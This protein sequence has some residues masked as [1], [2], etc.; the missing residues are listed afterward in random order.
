MA[1][2]YISVYFILGDCK[3]N[4]FA[5]FNYKINRNIAAPE[6]PLASCWQPSICIFGIFVIIKDLWAIAK[7]SF[8]FIYKYPKNRW[9]Q[10]K[11]MLAEASRPGRQGPSA[12]IFFCL[13]YNRIKEVLL[14]ERKMKADVWALGDIGACRRWL[15]IASLVVAA[16][17]AG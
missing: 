7:E 5:I 1:K 2:G 6:A 17:A 13:F 12:F 10:P 16:T 11:G 14:Y 4:V 9:L 8:S 3:R 15:R